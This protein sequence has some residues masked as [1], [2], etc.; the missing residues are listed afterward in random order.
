MS[1]L[2]GGTVTFLLTDVE[3][4]TALWEEAPEAM[5]AALARH[6][7]L[8]EVAVAEH[9]G[10]HI[11]PR[12]EGDSRFAVFSSAPGAVAA[13]LAI[14]RAFAAEAWLTP[15]PIKVRIGVHTGE[16]ELR[17]GDY[18]GSA[19]NRC[20][21]LRNLG[22]GGQVLLSEATAALA[23]DELP[24]DV[25]LDDRGEHR[26]R[27]LTRPERVFQV[28]HPDLL[29][30]FPPL[31]SLDARPHN[32]PLQLTS[33]LG[34]DADVPAVRSLL[35]RDGVRLVTL[36]GPGGTGKTRLGLQVAAELV[37]HF[38][39]GV[40]LVELA[41]ISDPS[42]VPSAIAHV[43]GVR[44]MGGRTALEGIKDYLRSRSILLV[45]DNFEQ[46]L[47]AA[48]IVV[49]LLAVSPGLK[50]LVTSR[51]PLRLR[52]ERE[53]AVPPLALP[54]A[55]QATT[56]KAV[57]RSP[58]V[59]LFVQRARA[60][61]AD[62]ALTDENAPAVADICARLDGLP[63]AIELAA[64]RVRLMTPEAMARRLERR[65]PLLV[66][67]ARDLPARQQALRDTIAWSYDSLDEQ[68][69]RLFRRLGVFVGG[70]TLDAAEAVCNA[71]GDLTTLGGLE[72][73][74]S[75]SLIRQDAEVRGEPRF[76]MLETIREYA[77]DQLD[78]SGEAP[79]IRRLHAECFLG[80]ASMAWPGLTGKDQAAWYARLEA[81]HDNMR[82]ALAWC[83][84]TAEGT[85]LGPRL[86]C[87]L[88]R[89]W[90][91][92]GHVT[93][94]REWLTRALS[95]HAP[96]D[97]TRARLLN[98]AGVLARAQ[99]D[100]PLARRFFEEALAIF[101]TVGELADIANALHNLGSAALFQGDLRLA[102]A[103]LDE[104]LTLWRESG[105]RWGVAM[106]L[107]YRGSLAHDQGE[108]TLAMALYEESLGLLRELGDWWSVA[109]TL[110]NLGILVGNQG[111]HARAAKLFDQRMAIRVE[112]GDPAGAAWS[113]MFLGRAAYHERDFER[114]DRLYRQSLRCYWELGHRW[115]PIVCLEGLAVT[116]ASA[117]DPARSAAL[118][119][120]A[121]AQRD[122]IGEPVPS[123][124]RAG[125]DQSVAAARVALGD[126]AF[127]RAWAE[128]RAMTLEQAV[129]Y[130]LDEQ[131]SA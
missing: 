129:A 6:D 35:L 63:L 122:A 125:H 12:G 17:D 55:G 36:T 120:A 11:R 78:A 44:D 124:E 65:L 131:P 107:H 26:L 93:E 15:R 82:A 22:H 2:P 52:G 18:Y 47:A 89:F 97:E 90:Q 101:R 94:G 51:A 85:H 46:I 128:G 61:R 45:L 69:R 13:A 115:E 102:T 50:V 81:D 99:G 96:E 48:T 20:A 71:D 123:R 23:R 21:R 114:A 87:A 73:L 104:S 32:L 28:V 86:A 43:L 33:L 118:Y 108:V 3:G 130:A 24:A 34:R 4:S 27:D 5:R 88:Y 91:R 37:D 117:G 106:A 42:L 49:D 100:V 95:R 113:Q 75:K 56:M 29:D 68:E 25:S 83:L 31:L 98:A 119:G 127:A 79:W 64:A 9:R 57:S 8:F 109:S 53:H 38:E 76:T 66:G 14:Q 40:F 72:S 67:G 59:A 80:L 103:L 74:V 105:D 54:D 116:A 77:L 7:V 126:E 10:V 1:E 111:D 112:L 110:G 60:I 19:V 39:H 92:H 84:A 70:W 16:A 41:P 30:T 58:A 121:S 62:F